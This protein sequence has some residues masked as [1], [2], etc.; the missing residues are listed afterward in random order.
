MGI[1]RNYNIE[2]LER[3]ETVSYREKGNSM[4][5]IIKS[6]EL[7]TVAPVDTETLVVGD[8]VYV[9][10]KGSTYT[11]LLTAIKGSGKEKR[12]QISNNH[13]HINGCVPANKIHGKL[14]AIEGIP[15]KK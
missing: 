7:T 11:H 1:R 2:A 9:T 12:F 15:Y 5:P 3:G 13:A 10:V 14:I 6:R 4:L 8:I